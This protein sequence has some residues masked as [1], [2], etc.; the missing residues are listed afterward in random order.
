MDINLS[1]EFDPD[2]PSKED[3]LK[4]EYM[5]EMGMEDELSTI[6]S[7]YGIEY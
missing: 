3:R 2:N 6:A 7:R 4:L 5:K 1:P